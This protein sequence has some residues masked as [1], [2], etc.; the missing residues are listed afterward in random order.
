MTGAERQRLCYQSRKFGQ[1]VLKIPVNAL[2]LTELLVA[3]GV[4]CASRTNDRQAIAAG[5]EK[6]LTSESASAANSTKLHTDEKQQQR[7]RFGP[8]LHRGDTSPRAAVSGAPPHLAE[9][10]ERG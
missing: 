3:N 10:E 8:V 5:V 4:L 1:I 9:G 2:V 6:M 7:L